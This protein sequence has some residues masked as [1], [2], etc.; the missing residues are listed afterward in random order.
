MS[1][2]GRSP[3]QGNDNPLQYSCLGNPMDRGACGD[4]SPWGLKELDTPGRLSW[5]ARTLFLRQAL[6]WNIQAGAVWCFSQPE[7]RTA[8]AVPAG[9]TVALG[10]PRGSS[11][12]PLEPGG[13]RSGLGPSVAVP[14]LRCSAG[15]GLSTADITLQNP[16]LL[17]VRSPSLV[18]KQGACVGITAPLSPLAGLL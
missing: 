4:Y 2:S 1:G 8:R 12:F 9:T 11:R 16:C 3:G 14:T 10:C 7:S 6:D 17:A 18:L 5:Y 15:P 13:R